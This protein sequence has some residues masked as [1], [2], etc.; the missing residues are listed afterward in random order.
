MK[1]DTLSVKETQFDLEIMTNF[2]KIHFHIKTC[3]SWI[4]SLVFWKKMDSHELDTNF[5]A[6]TAI[7][8]MQLFDYLY[9]TS[10]CI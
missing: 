9:I 10:R 1:S 3:I 2:P 6:E 5:N 7:A 8:V 4:I